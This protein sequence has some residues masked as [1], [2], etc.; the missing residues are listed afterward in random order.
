MFG[1]LNSKNVRDRSVAFALGL[2]A[3]VPASANPEGPQVVNGVV[4]FATPNPQTLEVTNAPGAII[5]WRGFDIGVG[6]TTRFIQQNAASAVLN[7]VTAPNA[8]EILG[9]LQSNGHVFLINPAGIL[10]GRDATVDTA[11]LVMSTL[12]IKDADFTAGRFKFEGGDS[13]G[14]IT[15]HGY[16][17]AAPN[18]EV[19]LI[20]PKIVNAPEAG[21]D[22]S[23]L[24]ETPNGELILAA[25]HALT[26]SSLDDP[27]ISFEVKA[28]DGEIV[29]LGR[30]LAKGGTASVLAGTIRHSGEINA[31]TLG[32]DDTGR[33]V[34]K[35]T[36]KV[37]TTAESK[38]TALGSTGA[39]GGTITVE[40]N[41]ATVGGVVDA[42]GDTHGG[43]VHVLGDD[44]YTDRKSTRLNSSHLRLSR[45]PSSA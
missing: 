23:G 4:G 24:I 42:S 11:G 15:N 32:V 41:K 2:L 27:N 34:L 28:P 40:G 6:E 45:M 16:I 35:A 38:T 43:T 21:N 18:G 9:A 17:K 13:S 37:E 30:L 5:N 33:I 31:D 22:K 25:G 12:D 39:A 14:A 10:I 8:S 44:L 20:A 7:R 3:S 36:D 29:N 26:I 1:K 19:V